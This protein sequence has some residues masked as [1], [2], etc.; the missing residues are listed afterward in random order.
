MSGKH[1]H[2]GAVGST[3]ADEY[4]PTHT[5]QDNAGRPTPW[6]IFCT[7]MIMNV[8]QGKADLRSSPAWIR[9]GGRLRPTGVVRR[10]GGQPRR[11]YAQ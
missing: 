6:L 9:Q 4:V 10:Y 2:V 11:A 3:V 1:V 7:R 5:A 8:D